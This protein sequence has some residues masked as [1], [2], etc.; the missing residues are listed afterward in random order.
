MSI[1]RVTQHHPVLGQPLVCRA[2]TVVSLYPSQTAS[3]FDGGYIK[4]PKCDCA[5]STAAKPPTFEHREGHPVAPGAGTASRV[6][7][8]HGSLALSITDGVRFR[9]LYKNIE[10]R[11][12]ALDCGQTADV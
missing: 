8:G 10:M 4:T 1:V 5:R 12:C 9:R 11:L 3:V 7:H 2:A 6:P